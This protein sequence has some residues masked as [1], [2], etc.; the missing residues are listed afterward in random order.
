M[1][2]VE[3]S[4]C[5]FIKELVVQVLL[6]GPVVEVASEFTV[7]SVS[8][9][10]RKG[11]L[12]EGKR[13]S[14]IIRGEFSGEELSVVV[15]VFFR[16]GLDRRAIVGKPLLDVSLLLFDLVFFGVRVMEGSVELLDVEGVHESSGEGVA[17]SPQSVVL[18]SKFVADPFLGRLLH[19][20]FIK[21]SAAFI[22]KKRQVGLSL[23]D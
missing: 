23:V 8:S 15:E 10:L 7:R 21:R 17:L 11:G 16:F 1:L 2:A 12:G 3:P 4:L 22:V 14:S 5:N 13:S 9:D 18:S 20:D 6:L 19:W